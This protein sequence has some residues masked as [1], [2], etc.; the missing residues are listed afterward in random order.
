MPIHLTEQQIQELLNI[1]DFVR[2]C[3][4]A[5]R[6]YGVGELINHPREL[7]LTQADGADVF[8]LS[9]SGCWT[10]ILEGHKIIVERSDIRT[11]RLGDR[12]AAIELVLTDS[13]QTIHLDAETITNRRTGCAAALAA[14]YLGPQNCRTVAI[15]GTG[16]VAESAALAVD[17]VIAPETIRATSRSREKR[18]LFAEQIEASVEAEL[19]MVE[20]VEEA[21]FEA[22]VVVAAVPTPEPVL[23]NRML[24]ANAHLSVVAGDPRT[25]QL[26]KDILINRTVVVDHFDQTMASGEFV[27][28]S[29]SIPKVSF[30]EIEGKTATIGDAALGR[31]EILKTSGCVAYFTGMAIQDLHA[32]YTAFRRRGN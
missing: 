32:G 18:E 8:R 11:G 3:D 7:T 26:E 27:R 10:G 9:L 1:G 4:E 22:E 21:V 5:F 2:S 31:L 16:R 15:I 6:L 24:R 13:E 23:S 25:V 12:T 19:N 29:E 17:L 14:R 28:Y 20:T 30:A